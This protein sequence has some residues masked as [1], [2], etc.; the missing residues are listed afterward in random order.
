MKKNRGKRKSKVLVDL[1]D[2]FFLG[3]GKSQKSETSQDE[4][5]CHSNLRWSL[6]NAFL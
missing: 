1:K 4:N 2:V 6:M 5:S 3:L